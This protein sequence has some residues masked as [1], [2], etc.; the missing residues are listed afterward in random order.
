MKQI[1]VELRDDEPIVQQMAECVREAK[2]DRYR[3]TLLHVY[4]GIPDEKRLV[5]VAREL[6]DCC[7]TDLVVGTMSAGEIKDGRLIA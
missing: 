5:Q 2:S 7:G 3:S 6:R 4:S 1:L